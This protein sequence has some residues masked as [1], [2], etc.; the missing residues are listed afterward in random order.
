MCVLQRPDAAGLPFIY[1][2]AIHELR[3]EERQLR[4]E[5]PASAR[6]VLRVDP[7]PQRH[8]NDGNLAGGHGAAGAMGDLVKP[9]TPES[10]VVFLSQPAPEAIGL[11][12]AIGHWG[13]SHHFSVGAPLGHTRHGYGSCWFPSVS[14]AYIMRILR[15]WRLGGLWEISRRRIR[16]ALVNRSNPFAGSM[17]LGSA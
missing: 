10:L 8:L 2:R 1:A 9:M 13:P 15:L 12:G 3:V 5:Q 7:L 4:S 14:E 6:L 16:N 17:F 11:L